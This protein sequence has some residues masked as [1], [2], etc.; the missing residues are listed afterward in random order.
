MFQIDLN[1]DID[2]LA[3]TEFLDDELANPSLRSFAGRIVEGVHSHLEE[4]DGQLEQQ[5]ENWT[6]AR[7]AATDR[8]VL[9]LAAFERCPGFVN[10]VLDALVPVELRISATAPV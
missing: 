9:R 1:P 8:H 4:L 10:G 3:I 5:A 7:M 6:V 2:P